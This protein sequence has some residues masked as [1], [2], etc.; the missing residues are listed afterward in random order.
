[1]RIKSFYSDSMDGALQS[2]SKE[3]GEEALI[4]NTR[5]APKEFRHFGKY[6]V[7][8]AV[9]NPNPEAL[10]EVVGPPAAQPSPSR[11]RISPSDQSA[12]SKLMFLI[13]PTGAGKTTCCAKIA[14]HSKFRQGLNPA[15]I[16]WDAG[17]VG[18]ADALRSYCEIA[19]LPFREATSC[20]DVLE[21]LATFAANDLVL[22]D[23]PSIE[24]GGRLHEEILDALRRLPKAEVHLVLSSTFSSSYLCASQSAYARFNPG[25][26]LP[27][28]LDEARMDLGLQ[29]MEG[30]RN[31]TIRW[32]GTGR[33][34]PEDLQD[35]GQ[36]VAKAEAMSEAPAEPEGFQIAAMQ[37]PEELAP[38]KPPV[39]MAPPARTAIETILARFRRADQVSKSRAL[40][41]SK[42]SAA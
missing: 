35:A 19:G 23:T 37:F 28:H 20:Q 29:G 41:V 27:T 34:V 11:D 8:C 39:A 12:V 6:E 9:A 2:A 15:L 21:G 10:V 3:L 26:L 30:L 42:S 16:S 32:C 36:V 24:G 4:L 17:R 33:S 31:L 5:E 25:Y 38:P 18:G 22:L 40:D 1:M 7:V 13:G 14:I